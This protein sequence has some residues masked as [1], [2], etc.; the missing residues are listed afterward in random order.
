MYV[1]IVLVYQSPK[2]VLITERCIDNNDYEKRRD[3]IDE[4]S[5]IAIHR[6]YTFK[7]PIGEFVIHDVKTGEHFSGGH[8]NIYWRKQVKELLPNWKRIFKNGR[9]YWVKFNPNQLDL[10]SK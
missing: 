8:H 5:S 4:L 7:E 10:N 2:P 6:A 1:K 9:R 3:V